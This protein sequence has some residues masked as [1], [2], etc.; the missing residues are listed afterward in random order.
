MEWAYKK[1]KTKTSTI[2]SVTF[3]ALVTMCF[4][5]FPE[6]SEAVDH[7]QYLYQILST[8]Q[9]LS[10]GAQGS[11]PLTTTQPYNN[12]MLDSGNENLIPL[13][14]P[15]TTIQNVGGETIA[16][17]MANKLSAAQGGSQFQCAVTNHGYGGY[18]YDQLKKGTIPYNVGMNQL[19]AVNSTA[20]SLGKTHHV[21]G[22]T[23]IHGEADQLYILDNWSMFQM[24]GYTSMYDVYEAFLEQ[25]QQDYESDIKAV[26]G[27][28]GTVPM[29]TDQMSS[30]TGAGHLYPISAIGQLQAA[31][32]NPGKIILIGPKYFLTHVD[33]YHMNNSSYRLWGEYYGKVINK[34]F[35][36]GKEWYPLMPI[37][38]VR[39]GNVIYVKFHVPEPPLQFDTTLV[40]EKTNKG[41]EYTDSSGS[42]SISSV[43]IYGADTVKITLNQVPTGGTQSLRYAFTGTPGAIPGPFVSGSAKGNLR[44]SDVAVSSYNGSTRLYN[45]AVHFTKNVTV[46]S[47]APIISNVGANIGESSSEIFWDTNE[48]ST[49]QV[50]YG[51]DQSYGSISDETDLI[52][53]KTDHSVAISG[54]A[55]CT[56]YHYRVI[57]NDIARNK[58]MSADGTFKT[59]G[60][61]STGEDPDPNPQDPESSINIPAPKLRVDGKRK[62]FSASLKTDKFKLFGSSENIA[63]GLVKIMDG[64]KLITQTSADQYGNWSASVKAKSFKIYYYDNSG[65]LIS[66]SRKYNL[67]IDKEDPKITDLPSYLN[68]KRGQIVWWGAKDNKKIE[69]Y[70]YSID[71]K[72]RKTS[73]KSFVMPS[74]IKN[75][76]HLVQISAYDKAG[77]KTSKNIKIM[78]K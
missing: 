67:H 11:P 13:V 40:S 3:V 52:D 37:G 24:L 54:L 59:S 48:G 58:T 7:S 15:S 4:L 32:N 69:H 22:V 1:M 51:L 28:A 35:N 75:G 72:K 31:E 38:V 74:D 68:K 66:V 2:F 12:K 78:V 19:D 17:A 29:F 57:S 26:T 5:I 42:S 61:G 27:Q 44:D 47:S 55:A 6:K 77:N 30:H 76:I 62:S 14:E 41:F 20:Q 8:G 10:V 65:S 16:S 73:K 56:T 71:G 23:N 70:V 45:W 53:V 33:A 34:V 64:E 50:E 43:E 39:N 36:E 25:W 18:R 21:I 9:S 60:C 63:N 46:D 49:S